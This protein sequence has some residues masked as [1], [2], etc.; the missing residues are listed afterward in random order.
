MSGKRLVPFVLLGFV[1]LAGCPQGG[2]GQRPISTPGAAGAEV[3]PEQ[4]LK[5]QLGS[6]A[7]LGEMMPGMETIG[8]N[9][10]AIKGTDA[11]K[12]AALEKDFEELNSAMGNP[13]QVKAKAKAMLEKL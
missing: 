2:G 10:A 13:A 7:E 6:L 1:V 11:E 12:G 4:D 9:I 8:D 5:Q 3:T